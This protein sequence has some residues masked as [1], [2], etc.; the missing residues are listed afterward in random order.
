MWMKTKIVW[1]LLKEGCGLKPEAEQMRRWGRIWIK[2][3]ARDSVMSKLIIFLCSLYSHF[4][5]W[6]C[7]LI[8]MTGCAYT[9]LKMNTK[10]VIKDMVYVI[11]Q[12]GEAEGKVLS[13]PLWSWIV[14]ISLTPFRMTL[15]DFPYSLVHRS[16]GA[17]VYWCSGALAYWCSGA[18]VLWL[19][20]ALALWCSGALAHW[21][22]GALRLWRSGALAHWCTGALA[23][24]RTGALAL[25]R[26]FP[27]T[28]HWMAKGGGGLHFLIYWHMYLLATHI[29]R[30]CC[31]TY[32]LICET[33]LSSPLI[34]SQKH[35]HY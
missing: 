27:M 11:R 34:L 30:A 2:A 24:W 12:G 32:E 26:C 13:P 29:T 16:T 18:L 22:P 14:H 20:S 31:S 33:P 9:L 17:L 1:S 28:W 25:W 23:Y 8:V 15:E 21:R 19:S 35:S 10:K 6:F 5:V 7:P 3:A 4:Y